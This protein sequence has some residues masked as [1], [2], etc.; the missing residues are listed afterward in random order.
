MADPHSVQE[1]VG[2]LLSAQSPRSSQI[3]FLKSSR[4]CG[5]R[6]CCDDA[7]A[8]QQAEVAAWNIYAQISRLSGPYWHH[9]SCTRNPQMPVLHLEACSHCK[10]QEGKE[11]CCHMFQHFLLVFQRLKSHLPFAQDKILRPRV[12]WRRFKPS[13]LGEFIALGSTEAVTSLVNSDDSSHSLS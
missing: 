5:S 11:R 6:F 8:M 2:S 3:H 7:E 9:L 10:S 12:A 1:I 4:A 13:A